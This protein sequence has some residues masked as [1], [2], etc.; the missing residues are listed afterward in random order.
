MDPTVK[1][2][3]GGTAAIVLLLGGLTIAANRPGET[4]PA[5]AAAAVPAPT[6]AEDMAL[7]PEPAAPAHSVS[8]RQGTP[9]SS[10]NVL[11]MAASRPAHNFAASTGRA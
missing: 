8:R 3:G 9:R 1:W 4:P 11:L 10:L 5:K 6:P 7:T 2:I